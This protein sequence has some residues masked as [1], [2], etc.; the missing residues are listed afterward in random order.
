M[1]AMPFHEPSSSDDACAA[2]QCCSGLILF[3]VHVLL[4][5]LLNWVMLVTLKPPMV[6]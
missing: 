2:A 6:V 3:I 4:L 5:C 1:C